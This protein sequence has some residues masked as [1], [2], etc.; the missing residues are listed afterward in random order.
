MTQQGYGEGGG[1]MIVPWIGPIKKYIKLLK[2]SRALNM[3]SVNKSV[4]LSKEK[5]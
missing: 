3:Y 1:G 4:I 2:N 5:G